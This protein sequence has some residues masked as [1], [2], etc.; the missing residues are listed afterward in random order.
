VLVV[1][2]WEETLNLVAT[3]AMRGMTVLSL[4]VVGRIGH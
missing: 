3:A 2:V 4:A 1:V